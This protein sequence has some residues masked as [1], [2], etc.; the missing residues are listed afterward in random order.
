[1]QRESI[2][3]EQEEEWMN[4][5]KQ[6]PPPQPPLEPGS[7]DK[8]SG[9]VSFDSRGNAVWEWA[10]NTGIFKRD[11]D[12]KRLEALAANNLEIDAR[13][14]TA[15]DPY[16]NTRSADG[17]V[18]TQLTGKPQRQVSKAKSQERSRL[19][20]FKRSPANDD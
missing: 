14:S 8:K 6:P 4:V 11:I 1:M 18:L 10:M 16:N 17:G 7:T 5:K 9:R 19:W 12:T 2:C 3:A 15:G 13:A 20:P